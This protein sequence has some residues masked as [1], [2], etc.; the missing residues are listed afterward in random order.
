MKQYESFEKLMKYEGIDPSKY[1]IRSFSP[2]VRPRNGK[3]TVTKFELEF[4]LKEE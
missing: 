1:T 4:E 3:Q 2:S